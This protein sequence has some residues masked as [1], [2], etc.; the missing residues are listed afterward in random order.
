MH[1]A[2]TGHLFFDSFAV[3]PAK[4]QITEFKYALAVFWVGLVVIWFDTILPKWV[5]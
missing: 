2:D 1:S 3:V 4:F 5:L